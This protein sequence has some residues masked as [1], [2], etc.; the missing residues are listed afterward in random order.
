MKAVYLEW[1]DSS[2]ERGWCNPTKNLDL[3]CKSVGILVEE[4]AD[5]LVIANS[6]DANNEPMY[7]GVMH[8][9]KVAITKRRALKL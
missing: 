6:H 4:T 3:T 2:S 7:T 8:I 1:I 9:P 5:R